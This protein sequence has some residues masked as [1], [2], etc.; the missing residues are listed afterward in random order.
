MKN[1]NIAL[2]TSS[3]TILASRKRFSFSSDIIFIAGSTLFRIFILVRMKTYE[4]KERNTKMMHATIQKAREVRPSAS[5]GV[6]ASTE[7]KMFTS[8][9][10]VVINKPTLKCDYKINIFTC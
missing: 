9:N 10:R 2:L 4:R 6:L 3:N 7:L 5:P 8:T 1:I